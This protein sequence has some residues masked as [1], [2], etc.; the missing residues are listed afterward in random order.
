MIVGDYLN[1]ILIV[2]I[3]SGVISFYFL[4]T[5]LSKIKKLKLLGSLKKLVGLALFS[6][7]TL[8]AS[9]LLITTQGYQTLTHEEVI[10]TVSVIPKSEQNFIAVVEYAAGGI[11]KFE[12]LGDEIM[13]DAKILKW[14]SWAN[15][16]GLQTA[17][18][19]SRIR[20]RYND[21][22][23]E[24]YKPATIFELG[25]DL[26]YDIS[27]WRDDYQALSYLLDVEHGSVSYQSVQQNQVFQLVVTNSGLLLRPLN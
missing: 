18:K 26:S 25:N 22:N 8:T 2:A 16:F 27:N 12:L 24:K 15:I 19:L 1:V 9:L 4:I 20:G 11:N 5:L 14:E 17:Y 3:V 21:I 6:S 23:D 10:A 7:V 13:I